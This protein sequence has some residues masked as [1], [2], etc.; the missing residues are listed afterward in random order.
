MHRLDV[1]GQSPQAQPQHPRGQVRHPAGRQDDE[2]RVVRDQ[3][4]APELLLRRP[5]DSAVARGQLER[6][7]LPAD[8]CEPSLAMHRDMAQALA[9]DSVE[10]QVVVLRHQPIPAPVLPRAPSRA[11]RDR[12]QIIWTNPGQVAS[13]WPAHCHIENEMTSP[14]ITPRDHLTPLAGRTKNEPCYDPRTIPRCGVG[15]DAVGAWGTWVVGCSP[16]ANSAGVPRFHP[17]G[18]AAQD[19]GFRREVA[20]GGAYVSAGVLALTK[21]PRALC[22]RSGQAG[23]AA[24]R[25]RGSRR[26]RPR[27]GATNKMR[28]GRQSG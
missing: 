14:A 25:E 26:R 7:G 9:D 5:A 15:S 2:A 10:P 18:A 22:P 28:L 27:C 12:A 1:R 24:L 8:Q 13:P 16:S 17:R 23:V 4:Q 20:L 11:H 3:M 21:R 19:L 6:A